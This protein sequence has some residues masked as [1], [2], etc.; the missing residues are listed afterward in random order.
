MKYHYSQKILRA[1]RSAVCRRAVGEG[2]RGRS[3]EEA[4]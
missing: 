3:D 4:V 2:G 1:L